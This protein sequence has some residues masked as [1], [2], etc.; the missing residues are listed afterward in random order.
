MKDYFD[1]G[2]FLTWFNRHVLLLIL[3]RMFLFYQG[4]VTF[5]LSQ[6]DE[7]LSVNAEDFDCTVEC[8]VSRKVLNTY[9]RDTGLWFPV[10]K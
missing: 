3:S 1:T 7:I 10:G 9:L 5:D 2:E 4:G 8:G 6:M